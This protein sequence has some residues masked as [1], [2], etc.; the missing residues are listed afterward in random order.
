MP[1]LVCTFK[2]NV[3]QTVGNANNYCARTDPWFMAVVRV[4]ESDAR[5]LHFMIK[6]VRKSRPDL[7]SVLIGFGIFLAESFS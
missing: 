1:L 7:R 6:E 4:K 2:Y 5:L 3:I